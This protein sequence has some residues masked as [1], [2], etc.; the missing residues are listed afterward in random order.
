MGDVRP[1][2]NSGVVNWDRDNVELWDTIL[3]VLAN[4]DA[5]A[6]NANPASKIS[7]FSQ[8]T[9]KN[10]SSMISQIRNNQVEQDARFSEVDGFSRADHLQIDELKVFYPFLPEKDGLMFDVGAHNGESFLRFQRRGWTIHA[11]EPD[12]DRLAFLKEKTRNLE[13]VTL[14]S[15][16]VSRVSGQTRP[17]FTTP[18]ST[19]ASSM[20][21]FTSSHTQTGIVTTVT[22][23]DI[24]EERNIRHIDLLKIDA[25]GFDFMVLQGFP[26]GR[27]RPDFILCEFEDKKT[28]PLGCSTAEIAAML[29]NYG[30]A[31]YVSEWHPVIRYG[32]QHQWHGFRPWPSALS[33][34]EAWGNLLAF[35]VMPDERRLLESVKH[36]IRKV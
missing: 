13:R 35:A 23:A 9:F 29:Q 6:I 17:W 5:M 19:G 14:D 28:L 21:A 20:R 2:P 32:I 8:T 25:E 30:Y 7:V 1:N 27:L 18:E 4:L 34:S 11:F 12:P 24:I 36:A 22:L 10:A 33:N 15:R 31:V 26:F 3:P 16:A